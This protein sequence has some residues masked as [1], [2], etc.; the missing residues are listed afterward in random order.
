MLSFNVY[1][2]KESWG[3]MLLLILH[4]TLNSLPLI[5]PVMILPVMVTV[6]SIIS[7]NFYLRWYIRWKK[8]PQLK[9]GQ[10]NKFRTPKPYI[11][12]E[13]KYDTET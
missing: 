8:R 6:M 11:F 1:A 7:I 13:C 12:N 10:N 9:T 4:G 2:L 5:L 3:N